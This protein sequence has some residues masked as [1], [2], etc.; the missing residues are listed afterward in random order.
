[1]STASESDAWITCGQFGRAHGVKGD[2][3]LWVHNPQSKL[4]KPGQIMSITAPKPHGI[5]T[6]VSPIPPQKHYEL[7][8][9]RKDAKGLIVSLDGIFS[10]E[11]AE[12]LNHC[13]WVMQRKDFKNLAHDEFYF[14]DLIGVTGLLD[15]GRSIGEVQS[16]IEAGAGTIIV[17]EGA[18][19][20][21]MV[22]Y[23]DAFIIRLDLSQKQI[24]IRSVPGLLEGGI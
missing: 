22:P 15:D 16:F 24:H 7:K 1:M 9:V 11:S 14:A 21:I 5:H 23:V 2:I 17:F 18:F 8:R 19:G 10:R 6:D 20:E 13:L 3:R 4:L 12:N